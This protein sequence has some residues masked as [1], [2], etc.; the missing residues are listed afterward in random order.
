MA[1]IIIVTSFMVTIEIG[2]KFKP[3]K[4]QGMKLIWNLK[5]IVAVNITLKNIK[6]I[7]KIIISTNSG[8][9]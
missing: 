2:L 5:K 6:P 3:R 9:Y 8:R 4:F 7:L 1:T